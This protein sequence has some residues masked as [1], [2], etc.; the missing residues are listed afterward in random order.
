MLFG[1][2]SRGALLRREIFHPNNPWSSITFILCLNRPKPPTII[3]YISSS[4]DKHVGIMLKRLPSSSIPS[5][6]SAFPAQKILQKAPAKRGPFLAA[7]RVHCHPF[8]SH[9]RLRRATASTWPVPWPKNATAGCYRCYTL[10]RGTQGT[11][12]CLA[13]L[14]IISIQFW[15]RLVYPTFV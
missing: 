3:L 8:P 11:I 14:D 6:F 10:V 1:W 12:G 13:S 9:G 7:S 4:S 5:V 2:D 15:G